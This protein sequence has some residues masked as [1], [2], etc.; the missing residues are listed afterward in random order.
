[1]MTDGTEDCPCGYGCQR[2]S[3]AIV[4]RKAEWANLCA[5]GKETTPIL[6]TLH[7]ELGSTPTLRALRVGSRA[8]VMAALA[9][10]VERVLT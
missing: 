5:L 3:Y 2:Y 6:R 7:Q 9:K 1:M 8:D 10:R 4:L